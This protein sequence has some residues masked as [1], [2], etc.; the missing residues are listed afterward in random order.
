MTALLDTSFLFALADR[1][2]RHH[3]EVMGIAQTLAEPLILPVPVLPELCYLLHSRL[4]HPAMRQFLSELA[5]GDVELETISREDLARINDLLIEYADARLDFADAALVS[6]AERRG[7]TRVLTLD[8]RDF[9]LIRPR[10][11]PYFE[12][13]P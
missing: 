13:L 8:R 10:H 11:C 6:I 3:A 4:G 7:V 9:G 1:S 2:D 5:S 12:I